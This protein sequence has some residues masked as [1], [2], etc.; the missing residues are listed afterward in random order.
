MF[1]TGFDPPLSQASSVLYS[2]PSSFVNSE[3]P[4]TISFDQFPET[5]EVIAPSTLKRAGIG[6]LSSYIPWSMENRQEFTEWWIST[7]YGDELSLGRK[8]LKWSAKRSSPKWEGFIQAAHHKNGLPKVICELCHAILEHPNWIPGN[9]SSN[10]TSGLARHRISSTHTK[11]AISAS[12][13][14]QP[15]IHSSLA[16]MVSNQLTNHLPILSY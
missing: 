13:L 14:L 8:A 12:P 7:K 6:A 9:H 4:E 10:G 5:L 15:T 1:R 16:Q 11:F 2:E 3:F